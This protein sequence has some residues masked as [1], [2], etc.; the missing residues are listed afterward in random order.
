LVIKTLIPCQ[1][2][3]STQKVKLSGEILEYDL[4]YSLT[5]D[6]KGNRVEHAPTIKELEP[7]IMPPPIQQK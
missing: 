5:I 6:I 3:N 4:Y 7:T 2:V 1:R